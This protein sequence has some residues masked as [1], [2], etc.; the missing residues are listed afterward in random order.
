MGGCVWFVFWCIIAYDGPDVHP[1]IGAQEKAFIQSSLIECETGRP[2]KI[3]WAAIAT[4][5][6]VWAITTTHVTQNFGYYVLLTELPSYMKSILHFDMKS[7]AGLSALPYF[8]M[9]IVSF[10]SSNLADYCIKKQIVD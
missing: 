5:P 10:L 8:L 6:A 4:S 7:N 1:W 2:S 9:W 3:P